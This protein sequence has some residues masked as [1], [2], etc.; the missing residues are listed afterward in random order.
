M[1][2]VVTG[3]AGFIG[4]NLV[5]RLVQEGFDVIVIDNLIRGKESNLAEVMDKIQLIK[6][7]LR[8]PMCAMH[9][10]RGADV[11]FHLANVLGGVL[12]IKK[13]ELRCYDNAVID[14]NVLIASVENKVGKLIFTSTA[15][16]YPV[17]LQTVAYEGYLLKETDA[18]SAGAEPESL[19]GWVKLVTEQ[20]IKKAHELHGLNAVILRL[21]NVYGPKEDFDPEYGHVIPALITRMIKGKHELVVWGSG[22]QSRSFTYVSDVVDALMLAME[23]DVPCKPINIGSQ[24]RVKIKEV[25]EILNNL[26]YHYL[27]KRFNIVYDHS[28]PMGVFTRCPDITRARKYLG[29]EPKVNLN[30]G[31]RMTFEWALKNVK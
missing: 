25:V 10:F 12:F 5:C 30:E 14:R 4:S 21:F 24:E 22:E 6:C 15:C 17:H 27:G 20:A 8:N 28:K 29:W 3:G 26:A 16:V 11:V 31:L 19:Y 2:V 13:N 18:T 23:K 7:D 1:K 9:W